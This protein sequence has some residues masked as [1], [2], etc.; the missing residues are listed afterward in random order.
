[1]GKQFDELA[2]AL[3]SGTSR[4]VALKRLGA[5]LAGAA[6]AN[7]F[8]SRSAQAQLTETERECNEFCR[9]DEGLSGRELANCISF[10]T[11][12]RRHGGAFVKVNGLSPAVCTS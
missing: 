9:V 8:M 6:L 2:K 5:G 4:R 10:C 12:C 11:A 3:A 7:V 1:M